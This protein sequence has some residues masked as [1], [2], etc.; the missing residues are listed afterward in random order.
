MAQPLDQG[1]LDALT[2]V[3]MP[4]GIPRGPP[5][6][7]WTPPGLRLPSTPREALV[8]G[9][10]AAGLRTA[11]ELK[12]PTSMSSSPRRIVYGGTSACSG[13]DKQTLHTASGGGAATILTI[14]RRLWAPEA[15]WTRTPPMLKRWGR[16]LRSPRCNSWDIGILT[17]GGDVPGLNPAIRAV[18]IRALREGCQVIGIRR[19]WAGL[20]DMVREKDY[21][22]SENIQCCRRIW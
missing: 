21:D 18:T 12:R 19:G 9:S 14:L 6:M 17:G 13:S 7:R 8:L 10:G 11:V 20:V 1:V 16:C 4:S 3:A 15:Q 5:A 22:N 2:D